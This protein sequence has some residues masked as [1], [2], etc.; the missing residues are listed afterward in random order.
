MA[1]SWLRLWHDMAN[2]PKWRTIAR[3]SKQ[4]IPS[5]IAVY[6]HILTEASLADERG[7]TQPNAEDLAS[8]L[9]IEVDSVEAILVAMEGRVIDSGRVSGWEKRQ[10]IRE[11]NSAIRAKEWRE[12]T[13]TQPNAREPK[14][15]TREDK[16]EIQKKDLK[17]SRVRE[18][19]P[20]HSLFKS[21][22]E[23]YMEFKGSVFIWDASEA[24]TLALLLKSAPDLN[25][26]QFKACLQNRARSPGVAHGE[27]PRLWLANVTKYQEVLNQYGKT[28]EANANLQSKGDSNLAALKRS[29]ER[30]R[31]QDPFG[32]TSD[33]AAGEDRG[34]GIFALHASPDGLRDEGTA[35]SG[36]TLILDAPR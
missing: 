31:Y 13:R 5:V 15:K 4:P 2:D 29:I 9:D 23:R 25:L 22:I 12:R 26:E 32:E 28:G 6:I 34:A 36:K 1:N 18:V 7:R 21:A 16:E 14:I 24:K 27:R 30:G 19:D 35:G 8:A 3:A 10:P 11:D 20:R 17:P 33:G